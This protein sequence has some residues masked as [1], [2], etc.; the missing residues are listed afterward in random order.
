MTEVLLRVAA[1][2]QKSSNAAISALISTVKSNIQIS[3]APSAGRGV[4]VDGQKR[5]NE[6]LPTFRRP[7]TPS[8]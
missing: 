4:D 1:E 3:S 6:Y 7:R 2:V 5:I 8:L